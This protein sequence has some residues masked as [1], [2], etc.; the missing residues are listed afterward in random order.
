MNRPLCQP[1][2]QTEQT[3]GKPAS[4]KRYYPGLDAF[5]IPAALLVIAIHTSPLASFSE[6]ADFLLTRV[7]GRVAVPFFLMVT[8]F[9][10]L[11]DAAEG[12]REHSGGQGARKAHRRLFRSVAHLTGLYVLSMLLYLPLNLYAGQMK[13]LTAAGFFKMLFFN[14]TFYH[15]WYLPAAAEGI[16]LV[17][18]LSRRF[19]LRGC[20]VIS[21]L[22][23]LIGLGGD[24]WYGLMARHSLTA[25]VYQGI[26]SVSSYTRNGVFLAPLFLCLGWMMARGKW[27]EKIQKASG[28]LFLLTLALMACEALLLRGAGWIRHDSMYLLLPLCMVFLFLRL[29][30]CRREMGSP[31]TLASCRSLSLTIY[32]IHPW[33]IVLVRGAAGVLGLENIFVTQSLIHF[34]TVAAG[35][36]LLAMIIWKLQ[37]KWNAYRSHRAAR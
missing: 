29:L 8:G 32:L 17:Y 3:S 22:L 18:L 34:L 2:S 12:G 9:F 7:A 16:C 25:E 24:S 23:Y 37:C 26:F 27:H 28:W 1:F 15:L 31:Q 11:P 33:V 10:L 20:L 19:S 36:C 4:Q 5:R 30:S 35:S 6:T 13:G 14:G 21:A